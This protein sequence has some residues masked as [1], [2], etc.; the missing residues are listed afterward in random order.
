M[1]AAEQQIEPATSSA[2]TPRWRFG[3][4][5]GLFVVGFA[6]PVLIPML[7]FLDLPIAWQTAFSGFFLLGL[8]ELLWLG[9][10]VVLGKEGFAQLKSSF[11]KLVRKHALPPRTGPVR[12][13]IGLLLF[14]APLLAAW[15]LPYF[16][17]QLPG[18]HENRIAISAAG[19]LVFLSSLLVLGGDFWDKLRSLFVFGAR[20]TFPKR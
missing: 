13:R 8:P 19:D 5:L 6:C 14:T 15:L 16:S 2:P 4:G 9:A 20:A 18:Y 7:S 3:L 10:A 11:W 1:S 12:Y 17:K